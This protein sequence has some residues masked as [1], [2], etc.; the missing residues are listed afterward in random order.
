MDTFRLAVQQG[1]VR[2][3]GFV[4]D[5]FRLTI[6]HLLV[7]QQRLARHGGFVMDTFKL[8]SQHQAGV[9]TCYTLVVIL[10]ISEHLWTCLTGNDDSLFDNLKS[11]VIC[12]FI[13]YIRM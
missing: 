11:S 3:E 13:V 10:R 4:M 9:F 8:L 12:M 5:T 7:S 6:Q 2:Y 1:L